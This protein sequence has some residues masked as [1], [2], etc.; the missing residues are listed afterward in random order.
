[1][2]TMFISTPSSAYTT[3]TT[4]IL[5][6]MS[7]NTLCNVLSYVYLCVLLS[8]H[9]I[10]LCSPEVLT[11]QFCSLPGANNVYTCSLTLS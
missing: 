2:L 4:N 11:V 9:T 8:V 5:F 7:V 1:M 10:H 6:F 3:F